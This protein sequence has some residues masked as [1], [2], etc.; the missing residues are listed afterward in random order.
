MRYPVSLIGV[1]FTVLIFVGNSAALYIAYRHH[2]EYKYT[3]L[4]I[5]V[6]LMVVCAILIYLFS[7]KK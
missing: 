6:Y 7:F 2:K 3:Y 4:A 1:L 5:F